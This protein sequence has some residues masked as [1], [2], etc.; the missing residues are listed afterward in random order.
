MQR[1]TR[2]ALQHYWE[3]LSSRIVSCAESGNVHGMYEGIKEALGPTPKKSSPLLSRNGQILSDL[4]DQLNRWVEHYSS[5]YSNE[6]TADHA[7]IR[8][9]VP[10]TPVMSELDGPITRDELMRAYRTIRSNKSPG[11]DG[12]PPE[13]IKCGGEPIISELLSLINSC[14]VERCIPQDLKD[15]NII[16]VY[17]NKGDRKDCNN[18]RGISLLNLAGKIFAKALLPRVQSVASRILPESQCGFRSARSTIDMVFSLRQV[19]E[20]CVEQ[21]KP[22][23]IVF[24]DLTKAFDYVSRSGLSLVLRRLGCPSTLHAIIMEFHDNMRATVQFSGS[25]SRDFQINCGVKQGCVLAPSLFAIYFSALLLRAFPNPSGVLLHTRSSGKLFNLARLRAKTKVHD[26][27]VRELLYADDA[28][29]M[30][31]SKVEL[32]NMCDAFA[33]AC[34]EFGLRISISKTVV[35]GQNIPQPPTLTI[36]DTVLTVVQK[37]CYLGSFV[38]DS[39]S[40]DAEIRRKN[41]QG[42]L[43]V[44]SIAKTGLEQQAHLA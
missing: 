13:V 36:N 22:L 19:Q 39:N 32:Q 41:W 30:A 23:Y 12:I 18:Y 1:V 8:A 15:A 4:P 40:I 27:L 5:L 17:K 38:A 14:W 21:Q 37:F 33:S 25:R 24:I 28:A 34:T 42:F 9:A 10:Q 43:N 3:S 35:L 16:T 29:L 7:A 2:S 6:V 26:L 11:T 31:Y 44:W 20:K